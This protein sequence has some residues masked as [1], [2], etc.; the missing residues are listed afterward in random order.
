MPGFNRPELPQ[1]IAEFFGLK[2]S[3]SQDARY[4]P[5][6]V[7]I[8]SIA[9]LT[10]TPYLRYGTLVAARNTRAATAAE[11]GVVLASPGRNV[12]L[13][14]QQVI[15]PNEGAAQIIVEIR[16]L[17]ATQIAA[18][19]TATATQMVDLGTRGENSTR[20]S[21]V[22][23]G[24]AAAI[25][26]DSIHRATVPP[27]VA[28][29]SLV[30]SFPSPGALLFGDNPGGAPGIAVWNVT[31]NEILRASFIAREWPLPG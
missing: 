3:G 22:A 19:N 29:P 26:G 14:V 12:C 5:G 30:Y 27:G 2:G 23:Q 15:V 18:L 24:G 13:A 1:A 20:S 9:A 17:S 21:V 31:Q 4:D 16:K 6:I 28:G 10:D 7:P 25:A 8:V 11:N